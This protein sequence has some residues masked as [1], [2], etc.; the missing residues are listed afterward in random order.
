MMSTHSLPTRRSSDL[1]IREA[2]LS[3]VGQLVISDRLVQDSELIRNEVLATQNG[4]VERFE[5]QDEFINER[6]EVVL[7]ARVDVSESTIVNYVRS[8]EHTS[9][10][11]SRG[12]LVC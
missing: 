6:G 8:E 2:M 12:H 9:E 10:L 4:F 5:V 7:K 3:T 11:Q 1:A